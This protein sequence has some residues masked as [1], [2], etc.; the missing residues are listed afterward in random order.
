VSDAVEAGV[1]HLIGEAPQ[2]LC[3]A[4]IMGVAGAMTTALA[5]A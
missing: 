2:S 4:K 3:S 1:A 5:T